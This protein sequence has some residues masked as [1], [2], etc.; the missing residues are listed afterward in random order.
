[1][2][3]YVQTSLSA[4]GAAPRTSCW[5]RFARGSAPSTPRADPRTAR[6]GDY[7]WPMLA[8]TWTCC[9]AR[10]RSTPRARAPTATRCSVL[11]IASR[12][13]ASID[14]GGQHHR[15][16]S[17]PRSAGR[18][19]DEGLPADEVEHLVAILAARGVCATTPKTPKTPKTLLR[20]DWRALR[21]TSAEMSGCAKRKKPRRAVPARAA[22]VVVAAAEAAAGAPA[23]RARRQLGRYPVPYAENQYKTRSRL[24]GKRSFTRVSE[25]APCPDPA[26]GGA[27]RRRAAT[28]AGARRRHR[29]HRLGIAS[30]P[31]PAPSSGGVHAPAQ[32]HLYP[33]GS[34]G[35]ARVP[36][37]GLPRPRRR[38]ARGE[39]RRPPP[40]FHPAQRA[41][42]RTRSRRRVRVPRRRVGA[43]ASS[44]GGY[45]PC[46]RCSRRRCRRTRWRTRRTAR[47]E[48]L[49]VGPAAPR[50]SG[51]RLPAALPARLP[52]APPAPFGFP[53]L[54]RRGSATL[55][56][57]PRERGDHVRRARRP[58][59]RATGRAAAAHTVPAARARRSGSGGSGG[60]KVSS[61]PG[62]RR[63]RDPQTTDEPAKTK[64]RAPRG[65]KQGSATK[66]RPNIRGDGGDGGKK[67]RAAE[68]KL[69]DGGEVCRWLPRAYRRR[70]D[71]KRRGTNQGN[72]VVFL[73]TYYVFLPLFSL[74]TVPYFVVTYVSS[75]YV[76]I[77]RRR[78]VMVSRRRARRRKET[79]SATITDKKN[80]RRERRIARGSLRSARRSPKRA[81]VVSSLFRR[82]V[83]PRRSTMSFPEPLRPKIK[84]ASGKT[85]RNAGSSR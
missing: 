61:G 70:V 6:P 2:F 47:A 26:G 58:Q 18:R 78:R 72:G 34:M 22:D 11:K 17:A 38:P 75:I 19:A 55:R 54:A 36:G 29:A 8:A 79:K 37:A 1:M 59:R 85:F 83:P 51:A 65:I 62:Y 81:A 27:V 9:C 15:R 44:R 24:R 16:C 5:R 56:R 52:A 39:R 68:Q 57:A 21:T 3:T 60:T 40:G 43:R 49:L 77:T 64:A 42:A 12:A 35:E 25:N 63:R 69:D 71:A 67:A 46:R 33:D 66:K 31:R 28:R 30:K 10:S 48:R 74:C 80:A 4:G 73:F 32:A 50:G 45:R 20:V 23:R 13:A 7:V 76:R 82:A 53:A 41:R 84:R 14:A